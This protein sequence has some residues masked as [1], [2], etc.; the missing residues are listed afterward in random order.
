MLNVRCLTEEEPE[1]ME[2]FPHIYH[3]HRHRLL[4]NSWQCRHNLCKFWCRIS[5]INQLV[6]HHVTSMVN[7]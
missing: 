7:S 1:V 2:V 3:H 5:R 6:E 4:R